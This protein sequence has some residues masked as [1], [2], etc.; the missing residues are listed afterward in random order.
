MER[1]LLK[2]SLDE[3]KLKVKAAEEKHTIDFQQLNS[4]AARSYGPGFE[5]AL[6]QVKHFNPTTDVSECDPL[7]EL[8]NDVIVY[9]GDG[10][11]ELVSVGGNNDEEIVDSQGGKINKPAED[12]GKMGNEEQGDAPLI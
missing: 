3:E 5:Q 11:V 6:V 7:K 1:D 9:L 12:S 4:D 8:G 10:E 2:V